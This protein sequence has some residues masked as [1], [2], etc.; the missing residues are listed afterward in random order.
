MTEMEEKNQ[1]SRA[2]IKLFPKKRTGLCLLNHFHSFQN[3]VLDCS[4]DMET[5][6]F[7]TTHGWSTVM[8]IVWLFL[9]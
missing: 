3:H 1:M 6:T 4:G 9:W 7:E 8:K 5:E 2:C